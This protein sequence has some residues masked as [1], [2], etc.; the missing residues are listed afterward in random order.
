MDNMS[1][2][3][4]STKVVHCQP[5]V[6][7][8]FS[9]LWIAGFFFCCLLSSS[10]VFAQSAQPRQSAN[11]V[12][13]HSLSDMTRELKEAHMQFFPIPVFETD[14]SAGQRYGIMPT[15]LWLDSKDT[16]VGIAVAAITYNP[17]VVKTGGFAGLFF[18]PSP[19]EKFQLF[20]QQSQDY[21]KD[22]YATYNNETYLDG[23]LDLEMEG[24]YQ[25][26]PFERFFGFGPSSSRTAQ[27]NFVSHIWLGNGRVAYAFRPQMD[28]QLVESWLR[29]QMHPRAILSLGDTETVFSGNPEVASSNIWSHRLSYIWDTRDNKDIPASGHYLEGYGRAVQ[30]LNGGDFFGGYGI[31]AKQFFHHS[32]RFVTM[33][34]LR[35][36][37]DF[38]SDIPFYMQSR[39][40]GEADL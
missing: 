18:Y 3:S 19:D 24:E 23:K 7:C 38:G 30:S 26:N 35:I 36:L 17:E 16:L 13:R 11:A 40:G 32:D 27:T 2:E 1:E 39:L 34:Y 9:I 31:L 33:P 6:A 21:E 37:Q 10:S 14:P 25:Q 5:R 8:R 15:Y 20:F 12:A 22:Y 29:M 28:I 4:R